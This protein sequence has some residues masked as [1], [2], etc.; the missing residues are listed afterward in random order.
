MSDRT[1]EQEFLGI[2]NLNSLQYDSFLNFI[3]AYGHIDHKTYEISKDFSITLKCLTSAENIEV[4]RTLDN[5]SSLITKQ[6]ILKIETLAR[7]IVKING[8]LLR[9]PDKMIDE[10]R[11]FRGVKDSPSE[12]EQQRFLLRYRILPHLLN[13]MYERYIELLKEQDEKFSELKKK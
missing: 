6:L 8:N 11:E 3:F 1:Q 13:E 7:A 12:V 10:W 5:E 4:S 2:E 9:F